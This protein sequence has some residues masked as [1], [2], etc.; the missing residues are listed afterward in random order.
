MVAGGQDGIGKSEHKVRI[1]RK[2]ECRLP[3]NSPKMRDYSSFTRQTRPA[4]P[5][6]ITQATLICAKITALISNKESEMNEQKPLIAFPTH[7]DLKIMGAHHPDFAAEILK[8]VQTHAPDTTEEHVKLRPSTNGN[9]Y[10]VRRKP[11]AF[12]QHL[13]QRYL[14]PDGESGVLTAAQTSKQ[15]CQGHAHRLAESR[16]S[17]MAARTPMGRVQA[18]FAIAQI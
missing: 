17:P 14:A 1:G 13:P 2:T 18:A 7:F 16:F 9:Y 5:D 4:L 11:R 8:A 10:R 12:G 15:Q 6:C 3:V